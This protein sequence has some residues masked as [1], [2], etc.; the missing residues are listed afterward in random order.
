M[1]QDR[2]Q[3]SMTWPE[4]DIIVIIAGWPKVYLCICRQNYIKSTK[5]IF[6]KLGVEL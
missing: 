1:K 3:Q 4:V 5:P 6:M 2:T